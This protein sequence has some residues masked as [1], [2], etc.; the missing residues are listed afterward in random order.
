MVDKVKSLIK[1][2]QKFIANFGY[3]TLF[4]V[5]ALAI[6][7]F[8]YPYVITIV[9]VENWGRVAF[10]QT[11]IIFF[12]L[13]TQFGF[14]LSATRRISIH[15]DNPD[16]VNRI[17]SSVYYIRLIFSV[18]SLL[19]LLLM[20]FFIPAL[21]DDRWLYLLA[22]TT[23]LGDVLFPIWYFQG[24][25]KM[26]YITII[27]F[28]SKIIYLL[29][30]LFFIKERGDYIYIPFLDG[31]G[32]VI[33]GGAAICFVCRKHYLRFVPVSLDYMKSFAQESA[34]LFVADFIVAL[35]TRLNI[36]LIRT[37]IGLDETAYYDICYKI[38]NLLKVPFLTL[39]QVLFPYL[40][41]SFNRK[42]FYRVVAGFSLLSI[43]AYVGMLLFGDWAILLIGK[44]GMLPAKGLLNILGLELPLACVSSVLGIILASQGLNKNYMRADLYSFFIYAIPL[45]II[46]LLTGTLT[47]TVMVICL[48]VAVLFTLI[49]KYNRILKHNLLKD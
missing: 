42:L 15:R 21:Y 36:I 10:A 29:L 31:L 20:V 32:A 22:L 19:V 28:V 30:I 37:F 38:I 4:Q 2:Q 5:F 14:I 6:P 3:L 41:K 43:L 17:F 40:S 18:V 8:I 26:G 25:E 13:F 34:N 7:L 48:L 46:Y 23:C 35:T 12:L 9:G 47:I 11:L 49:Y 24:I 33:G 45:F 16:E 27:R 44:E 1:K 39:N